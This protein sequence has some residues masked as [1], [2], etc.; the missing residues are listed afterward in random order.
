ME[1]KRLNFSQYFIDTSNDR[2]NT[3]KARRNVN[4][5]S[6]HYNCNNK[7]SF[8][9]I[10]HEMNYEIFYEADRNVIQINFQQTNGYGDWYVNIAE[11]AS[12]YY[13]SIDFKGRKLQLRTHHGW[14]DMYKS[15]KYKLREEWK[16]LSE[17]YPDAETEIIGWSL[18]SG[19]AILCAQDLNYNFG[20]K[21]YLYTYG[22][23]KPFRFTPFNKKLTLEYLESICKKCYNFAD[24]NDIVTYMPCFY[25]FT[26]INTV[27]TGL[28]SRKITKLL[29][30]GIFHTHYDTPDLYYRN[31]IKRF[32]KK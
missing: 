9:H 19:Q 18:G 26:N 27:R 12:K 6:V 5:K 30:P 23:V 21:S 32:M 13:D 7:K 25:G 28:E 22:S 4:Y 16:N 3:G 15:I 8:F 1:Y 14:A 2:N 10:D 29:K 31:V 24:V 11:F 17:K 20:L